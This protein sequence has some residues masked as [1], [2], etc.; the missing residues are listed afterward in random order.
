MIFNLRARVCLTSAIASLALIGCQKG[1]QSNQVP[2]STSSSAASQFNKATTLCEP[3]SGGYQSIFGDEINGLQGRLYAMAPANQGAYSNVASYI[4]YGIDTGNDVFLNQL[5]IPTRDFTE[6]FP[7]ANGSLL[8]FQGSVL[9]E[10]FALYMESN[11]QLGPTDAEGDYQFALLSDDGAILNIKSQGNDS[12]TPLINDDGTHPTTMA[13]STAPLTINQ[14]DLI[15]MQLSYYQGP[16]YQIALQ[17]LWRPWPKTGSAV[18]PLCGTSGNY[19]FFDPDTVPSTPQQNYLDLESR[20]WKPLSPSNF[21][22]PN[23]GINPCNTEG[24]N[25]SS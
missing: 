1:G 4:T 20:G 5:N 16:R 25:Q 13:C 14:Y 23:N 15:P 7:T 11:I 6:G 19:Q 22:I 24:F 2:L 21:V 17:L 18:D 10:W 3:M 12:F 8:T 9:L